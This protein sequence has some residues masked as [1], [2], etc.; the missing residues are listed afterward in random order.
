MK[1]QLF[2][3]IRE[4]RVL[5]AISRNEPAE[6]EKLEGIKAMQTQL[7]AKIREC[8]EL[9]AKTVSQQFLLKQL[10][11]KLQARDAGN[12]KLNK[13]LL[14]IRRSRIGW[15]IFGYLTLS[16]FASISGFI[17]FVCCGEDMIMDLVQ[18]YITWRAESV[19]KTEELARLSE[20]RWQQEEAVKKCREFEKAKKGAE[21]S[22]AVLSAEDQDIV[23]YIVSQDAFK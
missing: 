23:D 7:F 19:K 3:K 6:N 1:T 11:L 22:R 9:E 21:A 2:D 14:A 15:R 16:V 18:Q 10:R 5:E 8:E 17:R 12:K 20:K 13:N 4:C